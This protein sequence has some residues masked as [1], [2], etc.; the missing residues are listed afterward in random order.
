M[1]LVLNCNIM[2]NL[3]EFMVKPSLIA[4]IDIMSVY[5]MRGKI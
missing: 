2:I 4:R 3:W 5:A 1:D